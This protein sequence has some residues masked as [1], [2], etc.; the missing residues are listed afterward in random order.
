MVVVVV[1]PTLKRC[2]YCRHVQG[3][4][5][6]EHLVASEGVPVGHALSLMQTDT[7]AIREKGPIIICSGEFPGRIT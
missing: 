3:S 4:D 1:R 5:H 6:R 2:I 7:L